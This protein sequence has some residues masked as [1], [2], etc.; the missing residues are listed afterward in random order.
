M[1]EQTGNGHA[2]PASRYAKGS[3]AWDAPKGGKQWEDDP[4]SK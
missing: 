4:E 1:L 2:V 3:A